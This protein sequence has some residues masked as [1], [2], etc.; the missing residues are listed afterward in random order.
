M[1]RSD[2][3]RHAA[4]FEVVSQF[5]KKKFVWKNLLSKKILGVEEIAQMSEKNSGPKKILVKEIFCVWNF[6]FGL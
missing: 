6:F 4:I 2:H 3:C 5:L 1:R